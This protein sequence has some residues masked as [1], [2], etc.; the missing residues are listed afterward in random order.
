MR[1]AV[2]GGSFDPVHIGHLFI[3]AEVLA[4]LEYDR[5]LFVPARI[6][7]HKGGGPHASAEDR[8]AMLEAA[9]AGCP[10]FGVDRFELD[11]DEVSWTVVTL[12][13]LVQSGEVTGAPGLIIGDDLVAG[14]D[15]WR[16]ADAVERISDL[17]VVGRPGVEAPA[18][19]RRHR[20]LPN[21]MLGISSSEIRRRVATGRPYRY[22]VPES[23]ARCIEERGLYRPEPV[24]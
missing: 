7:P 16:E 6:P 18:F 9:I 12:R 2:L 10:G 19:A 15:S 20:R 5:I 24:R 11:R 14:F 8:L 17:I 4:C 1:T 13:H 3:A 22:L 23:V 21:R